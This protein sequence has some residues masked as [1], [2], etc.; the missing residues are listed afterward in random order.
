MTAHTNKL[1]Q[2]ATNE[3]EFF[4][5]QQYLLNG[6]T[7]DGKKE[8]QDGAWQRIG[9]YW[10]FIGG[11][12]QNLTGADRGYPW[13]AAFISFC[14]SQAGAGS[15]FPY[16]AGH[17]TYINAAIK[18]ANAGKTNASIVGQKLASYTPKVGDLIGYWRGTTPIT[19]ANAL[20]I[21]WYQSHTDIVVEID[22]TTLRSIGGNVG[23][24]V[25]KR[26]VKLKAGKLID[27]SENWFVIIENNM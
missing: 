8:Y 1:V 13:S 22:G 10:T 16:S 9:D 14:M 17:A 21:G 18:N 20:Q 25:T 12:Y 24:S 4:G 6:Q 26:E 3:W 15:K 27:T 5:R 23:H 2:V 7:I 11:S 19:F